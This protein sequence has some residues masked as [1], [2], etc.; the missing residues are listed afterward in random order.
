MMEFIRFE[1]ILRKKSITGVF[2]R[3]KNQQFFYFK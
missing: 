3:R 1:H 2:K